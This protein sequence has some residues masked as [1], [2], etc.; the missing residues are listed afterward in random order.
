MRRYAYEVSIP[1]AVFTTRSNLCF[2]SFNLSCLMAPALQ[3]LLDELLARDRVVGGVVIGLRVFLELIGVFDEVFRDH[4]RP[5]CWLSLSRCHSAKSDMVQRGR[6]LAHPAHPAMKNLPR[7]LMAFL[8]RD[9]LGHGL[10][11]R[12]PVRAKVP[13]LHEKTG[14]PEKRLQIQDQEPRS[15]VKARL[16]RDANLAGW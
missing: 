16:R 3:Q 8:A 14:G 6:G 9:R 15:F 7:H 2:G 5:F 4:V 10:I 13:L 12:Q 11:S 1:A